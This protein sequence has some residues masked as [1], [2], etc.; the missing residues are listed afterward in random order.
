MAQ[1]RTA[2][3]GFYG[4]V[5]PSSSP[6]SAFWG[7]TR[8]ALEVV[9]L[10]DENC[11]PAY[12]ED[13]D[14]GRRLELLG[15]KRFTVPGWEKTPLLHIGGG[16]RLVT[17]TG[18]HAPEHAAGMRAFMKG[19]TAIIR[20][21]FWEDYAQMKYGA[22]GLGDASVMVEPN[23]QDGTPLDAFVINERRRCTI[24]QLEQR[25]ID[26]VRANPLIPDVEMA[27]MIWE[28]ETA[29]GN[30]IHRR[31]NGAKYYRNGTSLRLL[32]DCAALMG[33]GGQPLV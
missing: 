19:S 11:Y 26:K 2:F 8:L 17:D 20:R 5:H 9:G 10:F 15:L 23:A 16:S 1:R 30:P 27:A 33:G 12:F 25:L 13:T 6:N 3:A 32:T 31:I 29:P 28:A 24:E 14:F 22:P 21:S 4:E 7:M 18:L